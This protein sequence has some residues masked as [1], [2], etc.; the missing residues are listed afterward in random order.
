MGTN[1]FIKN[2][3]FGA[4]LGSNFDFS[5]KLT[6]YEQ[7]YKT[8][9]DDLRTSNAFSTKSKKS[10]N[11]DD[12]LANLKAKLGSSTAKIDYLP[13]NNSY[14]KQEEEYLKSMYST[15][16]NNQFIPQK[17]EINKASIINERKDYENVKEVED[18]KFKSATSTFQNMNNLNSVSMNLQKEN[19]NSIIHT[20]NKPSSKHIYNYRRYL[21]N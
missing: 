21:E 15:T 9:K 16:S 6:N 20:H 1:N 19:D 3:N 12:Y 18:F 2:E 8:A 14:I 17:F 4:N 13:N 5:K 10:F 11:C 7:F